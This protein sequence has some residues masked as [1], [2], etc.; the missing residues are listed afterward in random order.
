MGSQASLPPID[1]AKLRSILQEMG[2]PCFFEGTARGILNRSSPL[3]LKH[4]LTEALEG[5][6][7]VLLLGV[8]G[9]FKGKKLSSKTQVLAVSRNKNQLK[10]NGIQFGEHLTQVHSDVGQFLVEVSEKLGRFAIS[11]QW[12]TDVK[13]RSVDGEKAARKAGSVA[14][15]LDDALPEDTIIVS[16]SS[17]FAASFSAVLGSK[18]AWLESATAAKLGAVAGYAIGTK[19]VRPESTVAAILGTGSLGYSLSELAT[20]SNSSVPLLA[21]VGND[22]GSKAVVDPSTGTNYADYEKAAE[23]L[24]AVGVSAVSSDEKA[25]ASALERALQAVKSGQPALVSLQL[26]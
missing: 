16:D 11:E 2:V 10:A 25:L 18:G 3:Y 26:K 8:P 24:G 17:D 1:D 6:D 15:A 9:D 20:A 14:A 5:A 4:G 7:L 13:Q 19:L 12:L 23:K 21:I 22:G